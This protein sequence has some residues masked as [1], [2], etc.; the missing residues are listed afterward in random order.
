MKSPLQ[1]P[2]PSNWQ[3]FEELCR[4]LWG[5][6]WQCPNEIMSNGKRGDNQNGV[7]IYAIPKGENEYFGIQC[8]LKEQ[9]TD[10]KLTTNEIDSEIEKAKSFQPALKFF[11]FAT[12]ASKNAKIE[13]IEIYSR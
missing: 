7:D 13:D 12:T 11:I 9:L 8:K 4:R 5:E 10:K 3:D 1:I 6:V 2:P